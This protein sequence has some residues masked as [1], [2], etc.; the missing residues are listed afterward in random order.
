MAKKKKEKKLLK[1]MRREYK[2]G[3]EFQKGEFEEISFPDSFRDFRTPDVDA[4]WQGTED[5]KNFRA[6]DVETEEVLHLLTELKKML[7][8][9]KSRASVK[10][11]IALVQALELTNT[12]ERTQALKQLSSQYPENF[13]IQ[14]AYLDNTRDDF[15]YGMIPS[16]KSFTALVLKKLEEIPFPSWRVSSGG[17]YL[18]A[19][20]FIFETYFDA[21]L[22]SLAAE[23][24]EILDEFLFDKDCPEQLP[25][26][27][28]ATYCH[29]Y[30]VE[31][32]LDIYEEKLE[33]GSFDPGL[34]LYCVIMSLEEWDVEKA[35]ALFENLMRK[36]PKFLSPLASKNWLHLMIE[37]NFPFFEDPFT[38]ALFPVLR[39]LVDKEIIVKELTRMYQDFQGKPSLKQKS[40]TVSPLPEF[41]EAEA[42]FKLAQMFV[43]PALENLRLDKKR[44]LTAAELQTFEDFAAWTEKEVLTI[45]GIGPTTIRQLKEN[46]VVFRKE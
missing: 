34:N 32:V 14:F 5:R 37:N 42:R 10:E 13:D 40:A 36:D 38:M 43:S 35:T 22:W 27:A 39:F 41:F 26:L 19:L 18:N 25:Y 1:Q 45:H 8:D 33:A 44:I 46:G 29:L 15:S 2:K 16:Y 7:E 30:H 20:G 3:Q 4:H 23:I 21:E 6:S 31:R 11:T 28:A 9:E 12:F 24:L 17:E